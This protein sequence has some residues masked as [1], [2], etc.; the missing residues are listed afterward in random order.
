MEDDLAG[1]GAKDTVL[2]ERDFVTA[3]EVA[4]SV[5]PFADS[6]VDA[7]TAPNFNPLPEAVEAVTVASFNWPDA[8]VRGLR[9]SL[10]FGAAF[11]SVSS[12]ASK[13]ALSLAALASLSFLRSSC[14]TE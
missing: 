7:T 9:P 4:F 14:V 5:S 11:P 3:T 13:N 6:A 12:S 1:R 8:V 2:V 10:V